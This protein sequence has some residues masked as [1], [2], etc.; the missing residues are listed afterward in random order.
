[1]LQ[2]SIRVRDEEHTMIL[3]AAIAQ[4]LDVGDVLSLDGPLGV[5]K[6]RLAAG[7]ACAL[8]A[9]RDVVASPTFTLIH[10]YKTNPSVAH[11]DAYR[12]A[13][14]DEFLNL[15]VSELW[16][17][18][19]VIVEWGSKVLEALPSD[20]LF[21]SGEAVGD[22]ERVWKFCSITGWEDRWEALSCL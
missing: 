20:T 14:A 5:G 15:G 17:D 6:T 18:G 9:N 11:I 21:V 1:M 7:V 16:D 10:E 2:H 8:G 4:L 19:I 3:G 22:D 13:D 12:L